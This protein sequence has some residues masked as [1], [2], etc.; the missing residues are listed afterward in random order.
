LIALIEI[1]IF[2]WIFGIDKGWKE[3]NEGAELKIPVIFKYIIKYVTPLYL[4]FILGFWTIQ[5]AI[6]TLFMEGKAENTHST[7]WGARIFM[8]VLYGLLCFMVYKGWQRRKQD[9]LL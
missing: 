6:P 5:E 4:I 1:I 3:L 2:G 8:V 7:L 9:N